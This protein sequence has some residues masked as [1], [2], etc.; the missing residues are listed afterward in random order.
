MSK[1]HVS[2]KMRLRGLRQALHF[3]K[4][5]PVTQGVGYMAPRLTAI[6]PD[7]APAHLCV[8][9]AKKRK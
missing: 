1:V 2:L 8:D 7:I 6:H 4:S 9:C 3:G 5:Y